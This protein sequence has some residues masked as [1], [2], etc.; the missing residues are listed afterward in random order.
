MAK[1]AKITRSFI[2]GLPVPGNERR[3]YWDSST[4][5]F[6]VIQYP[7][8]EVSFV[9]KFRVGG[10]QR[11]KILG[12]YS[13]I[14]PENAI[15]AFAEF[16]LEAL[17]GI[18][19]VEIIKAVA[20]RKAA[21]ITVSELCDRWLHDKMGVKRS[22]SL[23]EDRRKIEQRIK[24]RFGALRITELSHDSVAHLHREMIETPVEANRTIV[25]IKS[26]FNQWCA[27]TIVPENPA[28]GRAP[29]EVSCKDCCS[30]RSIP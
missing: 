23:A 13:L 14:T 20:A 29:S 30:H 27:R 11:M 25:L 16:K 17:K 4:R 22:S 12:S 19:K 10:R 7:S 15:R 9:C 5:G 1:I 6:G 24:P 28:A 18:D 26:M 3:T 2:N 8:G 21:I